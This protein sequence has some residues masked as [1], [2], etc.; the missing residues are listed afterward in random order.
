MFN[1]YKFL[2]LFIMNLS[3]AV[4]IEDCSSFNTP[5][6]YTLDKV[7]I[8]EKVF[9]NIKI[10][11][12]KMAKLNSSN[13]TTT[14]L[15]NYYILEGA[16]SYTQNNESKNIKITGCSEIIFILESKTSI[17]IQSNESVNGEKPLLIYILSETEA[18]FEPKEGVLDDGIGELIGVPILDSSKKHHKPLTSIG[19]S[20][21]YSGKQ[22]SHGK[23][24]KRT[25]DDKET[26]EL[27]LSNNSKIDMELYNSSSLKS[28]DDSSTNEATINQIPTDHNKLEGKLIF[29]ECS[30]LIPGLYELKDGLKIKIFNIFYTHTSKSKFFI[31]GF[32]IRDNLFKIPIYSCTT[33]KDHLELKLIRKFTYENIKTRMGI[34]NSEPL[35]YIINSDLIKSYD[36]ND[37][38]YTDLNYRED[39]INSGCYILR[40]LIS[41][42]RPITFILNDTITIEIIREQEDMRER[43]FTSFWGSIKIEDK[44]YKLY[45]CRKISAKGSEYDSKIEYYEGFFI[46]SIP[47]NL[48]KIN[49]ANV[50]THG[51]QNSST[52][53]PR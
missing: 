27:E 14:G 43:Y 6:I 9:H 42:S 17:V 44:T 47:F 50:P 13:I 45:G 21:N 34:E 37:T 48:L 52:E 29:K 1:L 35:K 2:F 3:L 41:L 8:N 22:I 4:T 28:L 23:K 7:M 24:R 19:S 11:I 32:L 15:F 30:D 18:H 39:T 31:E 12:T 16:I 33:N 10:D 53:T 25:D 49:F 46:K 51:I 20:D 5:G 26:L 38:R 40:E 36:N